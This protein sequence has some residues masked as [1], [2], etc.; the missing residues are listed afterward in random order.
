[1]TCAKNVTNVEVNYKSQKCSVCNWILI[2]FTWI[3]CYDWITMGKTRD[4]LLFIIVGIKYFRTSSLYILPTLVNI[5]IRENTLKICK[6]S[7]SSFFGP[8]VKSLHKTRHFPLKRKMYTNFSCSQG[9]Q[10][11][12]WT[13]YRP[14]S[15]LSPTSKT[16]K[17]LFL[18]GGEPT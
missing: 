15:L 7:L 9:W 18:I 4:Q 10:M 17:I 1:M 5:R 11:E 2:P 8:C 12:L 13:K 3:P 16:L 14:I 6:N